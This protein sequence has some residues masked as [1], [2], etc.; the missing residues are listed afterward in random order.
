MAIPNAA[1]EGVGQLLRFPKTLAASRQSKR[2]API[3]TGTGGTGGGADSMETRVRVL[4]EEVST[5]KK[6]LYSAIGVSV[7][8][9]FAAMGWLDYKFDRVEDQIDRVDDKFLSVETHFST[10]ETQ[11]A[12][13][14]ESQSWLASYLRSGKPPDSP[15]KE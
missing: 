12:R 2:S 15:A 5:T 8:A 1:T 11:L 10:V 9:V 6:V 13:I 14:Q 7:A 4:E 3:V